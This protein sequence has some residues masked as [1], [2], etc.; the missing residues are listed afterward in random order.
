MVQLQH[1]RTLG[2]PSTI[3]MDNSFLIVESFDETVYPEKNAESQEIDDYENSL[4]ALKAHMDRVLKAVGVGKGSRGRSRQRLEEASAEPTPAPLDVT[5]TSPLP[6]EAV[7]SPTPL[8]G[9]QTSP[10]SVEMLANDASNMTPD[11]TPVMVSGMPEDPSVVPVL[12]IPED[13]SVLPVPG[14]SKA[15]DVLPVP[16]MNTVLDMTPVLGMDAAAVPTVATTVSGEIVPDLSQF[17][18]EI[19]PGQVENAQQREKG[20]VKGRRTGRINY[21]EGGET[22]DFFP[23]PRSQPLPEAYIYEPP[24]AYGVPLPTTTKLLNTITFGSLVSEQHA[25]E[26]RPV[27]RSSHQ[28]V[29]KSRGR[30]RTIPCPPM[31]ALQ[32]ELALGNVEFSI[33]GGTLTMLASNQ[34]HPLEKQK[35]KR[36][37]CVHGRDK[38]KC[39]ECGGISFCIHQRYKYTC[40]D[41]GGPGT[42][43]YIYS[44]SMI[45]SIVK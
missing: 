14:M 9:I 6:V 35:R 5:Q 3:A 24:T 12:G 29:K 7:T 4:E 34:S 30:P 13:S 38:G 37:S 19:V 33:T 42:S 8:N 28:T 1:Q 36:K 45:Q 40:I 18:P 39:R 41:C 17:E 15:P 43:L 11:F 31:E 27:E 32:Q 25:A 23:L 16:G 21:N 22:Q 26:Q 44:L 2:L 10:L 20:R